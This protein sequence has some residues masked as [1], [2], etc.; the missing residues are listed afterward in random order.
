MIIKFNDVNYEIQKII[1]ASEYKLLEELQRTLE[2]INSIVGKMYTKFGDKVTKDILKKYGRWEALQADIYSEI[3]RLSGITIKTTTNVIKEV[4]KVQYDLSSEAILKQ[5]GVNFGFKKINTDLILKS[6][7][8]PFLTTKWQDISIA[9]HFESGD[10]IISAINQGLIKQ[11]GYI[12]T[13]RD[14]TSKILLQE[15]GKVKGLAARV[16]KTVR[17]ETHR[18]Q[19]LA[20]KESIEEAKKSGEKLGLIVKVI[21]DANNSRDPRKNHSEMDGKEADENGKFKLTTA[22]GSI[23]EVDGPGNTGLAD[24]DINC[25]CLLRTEI[26]GL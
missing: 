21:W 13:S 2:D 8:N 9:R 20:R 26:A 6:I 3:E 5:T 18:V 11:Q 14:I 7:D 16:L 1:T 10:Q 12:Q 17:T 4:H 19:S 23:V 25:H 15:K 22:D 24:E